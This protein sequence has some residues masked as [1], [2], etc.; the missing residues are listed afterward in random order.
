MMNVECRNSRRG[1][2]PRFGH[3]GRRQSYHLSTL[4]PYH[5]APALLALAGLIAA[6]GAAQSNSLFRRGRE[7]LHQG[8][9]ATQPAAMPV[10]A[11]RV[12][13]PVN[14]AEEAPPPNPV[15]LQA[16]L[17]AVEPPK[18]RKIQV[19]D[20]ITIVIREDKRAKTKSKLDL[21]RQADM[22]AE[23]KKWFRLG[24][25]GRLVPETFPG[26]TPGIDAKL[27]AE[28]QGDGKVERNDTLITRIAATVI[29]VKPNGTLVL[30]ARKDIQIDEDRQIV[31]LTG[32]CR[33]EDVSPQNTILSTQVADLRI[34]VQH[35][36]PARDAARRGWFSRLWDLIRPF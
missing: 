28:Y 10:G 31:T 17:I 13:A 6:E 15:L 36:G 25:R 1:V 27:D 14:S 8:V 35:F 2:L 7:A 32:V 9:P 18:K 16:S 20:P 26:G 5:L 24:Q 3:P 23:L 21:Q 19:H 29:D 12:P 4:S 22:T 30:S 34:R 11:P 33:A